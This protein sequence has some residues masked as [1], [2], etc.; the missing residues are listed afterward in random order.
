MKNV[1]SPNLADSLTQSFSRLTQQAV[2]AFLRGGGKVEE[3]PCME[4][5]GNKMLNEFK[6]IKPAVEKDDKE[7]T[8]VEDAVPSQK[9]IFNFLNGDVRELLIFLVDFGLGSEEMDHSK[10]D[11]YESLSQHLLLLGFSSSFDETACLDSTRRNIQENGKAVFN[12]FSQNSAHGSS[13]HALFTILSHELINDD[14]LFDLAEISGPH[15]CYGGT[16]LLL[17]CEAGICE[18]TFKFALENHGFAIENYHE[19]TIARTPT[20]ISSS[21]SP[22]PPVDEELEKKRGIHDNTGCHCGKKDSL[23]DC[24][25]S[26]FTS[27]EE[28]GTLEQHP[29]IGNSEEW[30]FCFPDPDE[31]IEF[32][33][34]SLSSSKFLTSDPSNGKSDNFQFSSLLGNR[35]SDEVAKLDNLSDSITNG[36]GVDVRNDSEYEMFDTFGY[37]TGSGMGATTG[38]FGEIEISSILSLPDTSQIETIRWKWSSRKVDSSAFDF[39]DHQDLLELYG[40]SE[41]DVQVRDD[42]FCDSPTWPGRQTWLQNS[43]TGITNSSQNSSQFIAT[44]Y[45][46]C[47]HPAS[48]IVDKDRIG[49]KN[50]VTSPSIQKTDHQHFLTLP[51]NSGPLNNDAAPNIECSLSQRFGRLHQ[52]VVFN[53][54]TGHGEDSHF[55]SNS[56]SDPC[57]DLSRCLSHSSTWKTLQMEMPASTKRVTLCRIA[58][59]AQLFRTNSSSRIFMARST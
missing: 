51:T 37:T 15:Q 34:G 16:E 9:S 33:H 41:Q 18:Q 45:E 24:G 27:S 7:V 53:F 22:V 30:K 23:D 1:V 14:P 55:E 3:L 42:E 57:G 26:G 31:L 29:A 5:L 39:D 43:F 38:A 54:L 35:N 21:E 4:I 52:R 46:T 48:N 59:R 50:V 11:S 6:K 12:Y 56:G 8:H 47:F 19:Q 49:I 40:L 44:S 17:N 58:D 25:T 32:L 20:L 13:R 2:F 28:L 36:G 10:P